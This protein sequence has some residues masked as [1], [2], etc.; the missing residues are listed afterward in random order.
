MEAEADTFA[1]E[2]ERDAF[3]F[4][5]IGS[6]YLEAAPSAFQI[7]TPYSRAVVNEI[8]EIPFAR[9]DADRRLWT[10]PYRSYDKLRRRWQ[11]IEAAAE[12]NEPEVRKARREAMKG[13]EE[14]EA[15][16]ARLSERRRALLK[17]SRRRA[18]TG[19]MRSN[20]MAR[21]SVHI[22]PTGIRILTR[23]G[24]DWTHRFP[25]KQAAMWLPAGT[26]ILDGE[27]LFSTRRAG[28]VSACCNSR[29]AAGAQE[30]LERRHLHGLRTISMPMI[31]GGRSWTRRH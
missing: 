1:D 18:T 11:A 21:L 22:E 16:K 14:E 23:G 17:P 8:R 24:H 13:T 31:S 5:P 10:V 15:S 6:R 30:E 3:A 28:R 7:R 4:D 26:A 9:W 19:F 25:A 12:R 20:W 2:K 29:S 27:G